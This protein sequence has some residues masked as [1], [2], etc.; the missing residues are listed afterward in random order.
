M[1]GLM[2]AG[3]GTVSGEAGANGR[4][5]L[6]GRDAV[7]PVFRSYTINSNDGV[8][9]TDTTSSII[10]GSIG[11][12]PVGNFGQARNFVAVR[13]P[14][15]NRD[16]KINIVINGHASELIVPDD[17]ADMA[18]FIVGQGN[19]YPWG[20]WLNIPTHLDKNDRYSYVALYV[21]GVLVEQY[22]IDSF[23]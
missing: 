20:R 1:L 15:G 2:L 5:G 14:A 9:F 4:A 23:F 21:E 22:F 6:N 3:C 10:I 7:T 19:D 11:L 17:I 13:V 8:T 18:L 16:K 12:L